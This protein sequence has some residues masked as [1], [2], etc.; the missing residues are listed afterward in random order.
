M[1]GGFGGMP[2]QSPMSGLAGGIEE[3][4]GLAM[5]MQDAQER[6]AQRQYE[7]QR[8][9]RLDAMHAAHLKFDEQHT[10]DADTRAM[11]AETMSALKDEEAQVRSGITG[12]RNR[13]RDA[14]QPYDEKSVMADPEYQ[15]T[16]APRK[17]AYNTAHASLMTS[18]FAPTVQAGNAAL[19]DHTDVLN[20]GDHDMTD[21]ENHQKTFG[22][23]SGV[24]G[25]DAT[26]LLPAGPN[27]KSLALTSIDNILNGFQ[28]NDGKAIAAGTQDLYGNH[29]DTHL[30][31]LDASGNTITSRTLNPDHPFVP[32]QDGQGVHPVIQTSGEGDDGST[33][34]NPAAP[35]S[36]SPHD[37][38]SPLND[39]PLKKFMDTLGR[40]HTIATT[41]QNSPQ[42]QD[43]IRKGS[44]NP[45]QDTLD[46]AHA[47]TAVGFDPQGNAYPT[48]EADGSLSMVNTDRTGRETGR[49]PVPGTAPKKPDS[50]LAGFYPQDEPKPKLSG[51]LGDIES[52]RQLGRIDDATAKKW[53]QEEIDRQRKGGA[54][55]EPSAADLE[56]QANLRMIG[57]PK[58]PDDP[59]KGVYTKSDIDRIESSFGRTKNTGIGNLNPEQ[60]ARSQAEFAEEEGQLGSGRV[61][62]PVFG[63]RPANDAAELE[64]AKKSFGLKKD[65]FNN[66]AGIA[67]PSIRK[68]PPAPGAPVPARAGTGGGSAGQ[69]TPRAPR[70]A[71]PDGFTE[72][73]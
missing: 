35:P 9:D 49:V 29:F 42:L 33:S 69:I 53:E 20:A 64:A 46:Y 8:Q 67:A 17:G 54:G 13:L 48:R 27:Q 22:Y 47:A 50:G 12:I 6:R 38:N 73:H 39:M 18:I 34:T 15:Q 25:A 19:K 63:Y 16:W 51:I 10:K 52:L 65:A 55:R 30:G 37:P 43:A 71:P 59:S 60:Y 28:N 36:A 57:Q 44:Q 68:P 2:Y 7:N 58:D 70:P 66:A 56:H 45:S 5:R 14:G 3:G 4:V 1:G 41:V 26:T 61:K 11:H 31:Q 23:L 72:L 32:T 40:T 21:P 24:L 62:D